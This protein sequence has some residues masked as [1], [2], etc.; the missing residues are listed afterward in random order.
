MT[1]DDIISRWKLPKD[2]LEFLQ[3]NADSLFFDTEEYG[4]LE[5]FGAQTLIG[6]QDGYS[7]E[8]ID[9]WNPDMVVIAS[10]WGDPFCIDLTKDASPVY[11]AFH[12]EG[13]WDFNEEYDSIRT[14][15]EKWV[16]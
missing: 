16:K 11:F 2:Y 9:D 7:G 8:P 15:L 3:T 1:I 13:E 6:G 12:G 4:E 14:F 5:I 10:A